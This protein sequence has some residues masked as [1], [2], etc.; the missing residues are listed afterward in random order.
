MQKAGSDSSD[1]SPERGSE[2]GSAHWPDDASLGRNN[3]AWL[4]FWVWSTLFLKHSKHI[5]DTD[6]ENNN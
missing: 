6:N 2:S 5:H 1:E 3:R 4:R